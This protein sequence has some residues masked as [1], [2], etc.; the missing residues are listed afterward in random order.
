MKLHLVSFLRQCSSLK[1]IRQAHGFMVPT[2]L[3]NDN[4]VFAQ[5]IQA[6]SSL[7]YS[8]Y[9]Y[10]VFIH[11]KLKPNI[12]LYNTMINTLSPSHAIS[13]Y[14]DIFF[15]D[16]RP[17]TYSVPY[18]LKAVIRLSAVDVG[19]QI[20]C[21]AIG[22]G[23]DSD[24]CVG[25]SLVRMYSFCGCVLEA[26]K[27][28]D[29]M[30]VRDVALWNA[31]VTGY[32]KVADVDNAWRVFERMPERDLI[33]WTSV[34]AGFAKMKRPKE[35]IMVF[36]RMQLENL[37]ADEVT[38]LAVLSAC[39]HLGSVVL[40]ERIHNYMQK[41]GFSR[42]LH[43][44]N[45]LI[46]MYAKS[47]NIRKALDVFQSMKERSVVT[48]T[49]M[50]SGLALHGLGREAIEMF[51]QMESALVKPNEITFIAILSACSHAGLVEM[52]RWFFNNMASRHGI[53]LKV[54][55]YG[56]MIDLLGRAGY[57]QEACEL[58]R[59]M[60]FQTN[61][62]IWGSLLAASNIHGESDLGEHALQQLMMLE[63]Q[64]S[65]SYTLLSNIY[66]A[67][68][69]WDESGMIRKVMRDTGVKKM[70]GGSFIEINNRVHE[71][72]AGDTS[73]SEFYKIFEVLYD[74]FNQLKI[75]GHIQKEG[76]EL[77]AFDE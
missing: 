60:P 17:D 43:L 9:A 65:G 24:V 56:C 70:A 46:D 7:G 36:R 21:Q 63:P 44:N 34:I 12:Y 41:R 54:E 22:T 16:L 32:V 8:T 6:C 23:L 45:A 49:T 20:H 53:Q 18:V 11:K 13:L 61:A 51:S 40:G 72:I 1:H 33:S 71:F 42:K 66:A 55:H 25:T 5:F 3:Q 30:G 76:V 47:G 39:A 74:I 29:G 27:V 67:S 58:V 57:L 62:A 38:I 64:N 19:R 35:A 26:R 14:N 52:G 15:A 73:H 48:W 75:A 2:G 31:M 68:G 59:G 37:E 28:F 69:S 10:L 77:L 50:M 4:V